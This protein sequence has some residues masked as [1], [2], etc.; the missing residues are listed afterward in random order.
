ML[1]H[2]IPA[3][4]VLR[5][6]LRVTPLRSRQ[7]T[8]AADPSPITRTR[9]P[10]LACAARLLQVALA[11]T[12]LLGVAP[13]MAGE[14]NGTAA[15]SQPFPLP[16]DAVLDLQ[17]IE[18]VGAGDSTVLVGRTRTPVRGRAPF[19]FS[20]PYL[21]A[22]IRP[23]SRYSLRAGIRQ[24]NRLLFSTTAAMAVIPGRPAPVRVLLEPVGDAP[25][26]GLPWLRAP[27]A[28]VPTPLG[29]PRQ[30]QQFRLDPLTRELTGSGD[31]NRFIGTYALQGENLRLE[32][33]GGTR[34]DC[35]PAVN[36]DEARF[37]ADLLE[38]RRWRLD[39]QGRL[40]LLDESGDVRLLMEA[41]PL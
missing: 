4:G 25:L 18:L 7:W 1:R 6:T 20:V 28:S 5:R 31:C 41:R 26:R 13:V 36:A 24:A 32:P 2:P 8:T 14:L 38:V 27:A 21:D 34:L 10:A 30:E 39:R 37:L 19:T 12:T 11:S 9:R 17:L 22:A 40:E 16:S 33:A 3:A 15:L 35:E 23:D 29:A